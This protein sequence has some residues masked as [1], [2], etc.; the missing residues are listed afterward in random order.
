MKRILIVED[1]PAIV[2]Y[3]RAALEPLALD[4]HAVNGVVA[5]WGMLRGLGGMD[6]VI[7]DSHVLGNAGIAAAALWLEHP[8]MRFILMSTGAPQIP[9]EAD[10]WLVG[11]LPED[12]ATHLEKP[13]APNL[14]RQIVR[15]LIG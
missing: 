14:L 3:I 9:P 7:A 11:L 8:A 6:L 10:G 15:R 2:R 12:G 5:A 1:D 4:I 13:F